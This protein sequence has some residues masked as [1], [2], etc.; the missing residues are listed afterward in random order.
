MAIVKKKTRSQ[1]VHD[2]EVGSAEQ[3]GR[4]QVVTSRAVPTQTIAFRAGTDL[5]EALDRAAVTDHR[6]RGNLIQ[7]ALWQYIHDRKATKRR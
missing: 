4:A 7:H 1:M 2:L 3:V 5:I 6:T